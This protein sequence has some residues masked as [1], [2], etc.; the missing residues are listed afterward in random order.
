MILFRFTKIVIKMLNRIAVISTSFGCVCSGMKRR[1][2]ALYSSIEFNDALN[3]FGSRNH[4]RYRSNLQSSR[5]TRLVHGGSKR[6]KKLN[7]EFG[8][9]RNSLANLKM[10]CRRE[11]CRTCL[12]NT[13][14]A[15][16]ARGFDSH[17]MR[18]K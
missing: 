16:S 9:G 8:Y 12:R 14:N 1:K 17:V 10:N 6:R 11:S 7:F 13:C 15:L 3:I 4:R 18:S 2:N 5:P